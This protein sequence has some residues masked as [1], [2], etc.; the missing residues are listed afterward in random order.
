MG[1][2]AGVGLVVVER[3]IVDKRGPGD[4]PLSK[5]AQAGQTVEADATPQ[6]LAIVVNSD[7]SCFPFT[8]TRKV[9]QLGMLVL[10]HGLCE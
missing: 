3:R 2:W 4:W 9:C 8:H 10:R 5:A 1:P 6:F 7:T